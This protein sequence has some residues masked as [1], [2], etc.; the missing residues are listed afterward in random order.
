MMDN[1]QTRES[2]SRQHQ[3]MPRSGKT[4]SRDKF[5]DCFQKWSESRPRVGIESVIDNYKR[6]RYRGLKSFSL[7]EFARQA[8]RRLLARAA[9]P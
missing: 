9:R 1:V 4:R 7:L 5:Q 3:N 6:V 8:R 2:A